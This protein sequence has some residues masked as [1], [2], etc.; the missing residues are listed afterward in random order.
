MKKSVKINAILNTLKQLC[1]VVFPLITVP[2][3]SQVLQAE[4]YG[5]VNFSGSIVGYFS[6]IAGLGICNYAIR[7]GAAIREN[8]YELEKF[9]NEVFT[10]NLYSTLFSYCLLVIM[11]FSA[12]T[13]RNYSVLIF[14]QSTSILFSTLGTD[15]INAIHEDYV[16]ITLRYLIIQFL[17]I[18]AL[19]LFVKTSEDYI[20]YAAINVF[21]SAGGNLFN[22]FYIRSKYSKL[23][24]VRHCNLR[25]HLSPILILFF[26][27]VAVT[28][29]VNSDTTILGVV[30]GDFAVGIYGVATKIYLIVKQV[31]NAVIIVSLPRLSAYIGQNNKI[32]YHALLYKIFNAVVVLVFPCIVGIFMLSKEIILA[33]SGESYAVGFRALQI[34]SFSLG[35]AV[36]ACFYCVCVL[37]PQK[38]DKLCLIASVVSGSLNIILNIIVVPL[39]SYNGAALTTL[40]S[41]MIVFLI[42]IYFA[43]KLQK[44]LCSMRT[45]TST[46]VGCIAVV[47]ICYFIKSSIQDLWGCI[48]LSVVCSGISY[49]F[50]MILFKNDLVMMGIDTVRR[51]VRSTYVKE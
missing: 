8:R 45:V 18:V 10:I 25:R 1:Q 11:Y 40:L 38:K 16:Y 12:T 4:N 20:I 24:L 14:I 39:W 43:Q 2:Y 49:L 31:L 37:L 33:I 42:Y 9:Q 17:S 48:I 23:R 35:F 5:K 26:N 47:A 22:I 15:W 36:L 6:L 19:F 27:T 13:V 7:E 29:Y 28:I 44:S 3:V 30:Q 51:K 34:L 21:A 46:F 50:I 32:A 41:E